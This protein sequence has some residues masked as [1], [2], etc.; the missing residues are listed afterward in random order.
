[1]GFAPR[2]IATASCWS[3]DS[4][5]STSALGNVHPNRWP[6]IEVLL[7][8]FFHAG[9]AR[10]GYPRGVQD[11]RCARCGAQAID[12]VCLRCLCAADPAPIAIPGI[13]LGDE[14]GRGGSATVYSGRRIADD[15]AVAVKVF[16]ADLDQDAA[17]TARFYR[18]AALLQSLPHPN[19][20]AIED[21]G[22]VDLTVDR[23]RYIVTELAVGGPV[24]DRIPLDRAEALEVVQQVCAAL[25]FAHAHGIV[26]RDVKPQNVLVAADGVI[27]LGDFGA[28]RQVAAT[29]QRITE[30]GDIVGTPY[31]IAPEAMRGAPHDPRMDVY[32][33]GVLL[34]HLIT[35]TLPIGYFEPLPGA[36]DPV[37]RRALAHNPDRRYGT[38]VE[39]S[40]ALRRAVVA[41][42][43]TATTPTATRFLRRSTVAATA[44]V[45]IASA[46]ALA[47]WSMWATR[48]NGVEPE[49]N[50]A[51]NTGASPPSGQ[52]TTASTAVLDA[53]LDV[54][55]TPPPIYADHRPLD[56]E[57]RRAS[58]LARDGE[59]R[60]A[61]PER[62]ASRSAL[63][64]DDKR[65]ERSAN[66]N[67]ETDGAGKQP[68]VAGGTIIVAARPWAEVH[69][70]GVPRGRAEPPTT[71]FRVE[72]GAHTVT[73]SHPT[74]GKQTTRKVTVENRATVE[75]RADL[76]RDSTEPA[77]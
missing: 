60:N 57:A 12:E 50:A 53:G 59:M 23:R 67:R 10:L 39:L 11:R 62:K 31:Y 73:L 66:R 38:I 77:P 41:P 46:V 40:D 6:R 58:E 75:I 70:D 47:A 43:P 52:M 72:P 19:I 37:V 74:T 21:W 32:A 64:R 15:R 18:E 34:Y 71:R 24:S 5:S 36:L 42:T 54:Q 69:I 27:K 35:G 68:G 26:H 8:P 30:T 3:G 51:A 28:A 33:V 29:D 45:G 14:I 9:K 49:R 17:T 65:S 25:A 55:A 22:E 13:E 1:M 16:Q 44:V 7:P 20:L 61:R 48:G 2:R 4:S 63:P 56:L 76:G